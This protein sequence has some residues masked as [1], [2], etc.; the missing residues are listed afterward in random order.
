MLDLGKK[1]GIKPG[2][3]DGW[4]N[5]SYSDIVKAN[6]RGLIGQYRSIAGLLKAMFPEHTWDLS[7]FKKRP[8]NYWSSLENQRL[9]LEDLGEKLRIKKGDFEGWYKVSNR[10]LTDNGGGRLLR[11]HNSSISTLLA[12]VYPSHNWEPSRFLNR[13]RN[14]WASKER[15][16]ELIEVIRLKLNLSENLASWY[17]VSKEDMIKAGAATLLFYANNSPYQLLKG[18]YPEHDWDPT[19]F[20]GS[21]KNTTGGSKLELN[22]P[23]D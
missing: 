21:R 19:K 23:I 4:Y 3:Y 17:N 20:R 9:F 1:L 8:R 15:Q 6:G 5:L 11:A 14:Y 12:E 22:L 2:N 18:V 16:R 13:P 7:K 10:D